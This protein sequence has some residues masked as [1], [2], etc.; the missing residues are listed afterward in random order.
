MKTQIV[1]IYTYP[2][3]RTL[4]GYFEMYKNRIDG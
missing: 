4:N 3:V 1:I 2:L